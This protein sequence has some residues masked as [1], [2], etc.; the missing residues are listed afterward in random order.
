MFTLEPTFTFPMQS[1][2]LLEH[3]EATRKILQK[4]IP[5][6]LFFEDKADFIDWI[7]EAL[8]TVKW[9]ECRE[10]PDTISVFLLCHSCKGLSIDSF[11][12]DLLKKRL[13][14]DREVTTLSFQHMS[15]HLKEIATNSFF[16][17]EMKIL[18]ENSR[19]LHYIQKNLP[20]LAKE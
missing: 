1:E 5:E 18:I 8:P 3:A 9:T 19:D 16:V 12:L 11:F 7:E 2:T 6:E 13:V 4:I 15:F 20:L 17:A 10:I 14:P